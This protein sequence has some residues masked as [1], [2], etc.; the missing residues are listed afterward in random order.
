MTS[1]A[2]PAT[3]LHE[4]TD[5]TLR[6]METLLRLT[7]PGLLRNSAVVM[8]GLTVK[9]NALLLRLKVRGILSLV[10][11]DYT[12]AVTV[13]ETGPAA[14]ELGLDLLSGPGLAKLILQT[15]RRVPNRLVNELLELLALEGLGM[16]GQRIVVDHATLIR[17]LAKRG[18]KR[19]QTTGAVTT[20]V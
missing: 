3:L 12:I 2:P 1:N 4:G 18:R 6:L 20:P 9:H 13:L 10:D 17:S 16:A 14:S 8:Q 11:G 19:G 7:L 15:F 5:C